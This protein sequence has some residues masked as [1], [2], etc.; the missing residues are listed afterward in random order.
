M[1]KEPLQYRVLLNSSTKE[2]E[3]D[4]WGSRILALVAWLLGL[5]P[6]PDES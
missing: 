3:K 5:K 4:Q 6:A 2:E 1:E